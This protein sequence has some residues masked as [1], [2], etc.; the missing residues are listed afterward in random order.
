MLYIIIIII[1]II[2]LLLLL[3]DD[4]TANYQITRK[5]YHTVTDSASNMVKDYDNQDNLSD[6]EADPLPDHMPYFANALHITTYDRNML[7]EAP[8]SQ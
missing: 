4:T 7:Y 8:I 5:I 1:I 2:I 3:Y 6:E